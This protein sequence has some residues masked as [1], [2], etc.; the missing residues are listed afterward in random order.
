LSKIHSYRLL[1]GNFA[2]WANFKINKK[3]KILHSRFRM[4]FVIRW[5][6]RMVQFCCLLLKTTLN[7][8]A[9]TK[10][11]GKVFPDIAKV[12]PCKLIVL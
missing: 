2:H 3:K 10:G 4:F 6:Q 11:N 8:F 7:Q 1:F 12:L 9:Y 5:T